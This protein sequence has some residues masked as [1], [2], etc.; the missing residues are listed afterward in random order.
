[1]HIYVYVCLCI[2]EYSGFF[3][4]ALRGQTC[5]G[6]PKYLTLLPR[7][8]NKHCLKKH[9]EQLLALFET[10]WVGIAALVI[11][12]VYRNP[13]FKVALAFPSGISP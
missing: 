13:W 6:L 2:Y 9:V 12:N 1:M 3:F 11:T 4:K 7:P 10:S 5:A 8:R